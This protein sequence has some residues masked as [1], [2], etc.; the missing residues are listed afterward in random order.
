MPQVFTTTF[1][2]DNAIRWQLYKA[3]LADKLIDLAADDP[4]CPDAVKESAYTGKVEVKGNEFVV[5][6][7]QGE[8]ESKEN[9]MN[10]NGSTLTVPVLASRQRN[11][12]RAA[13]SGN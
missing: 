3:S 13:W 2:I 11:S 6:L 5:T 7:T 12:P 9:P 10:N 8:T 1:E 4:F